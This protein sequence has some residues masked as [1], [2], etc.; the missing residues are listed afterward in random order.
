[1]ERAEKDWIKY[2]V[3]LMNQLKSWLGDI[4]NR[5]TTNIKVRGVR[6]FSTHSEYRIS[7]SAE[8]NDRIP[9]YL[10]IPRKPVKKP[11]P[12]IFAAHQCGHHCDIGKEQ[13]VGKFIDHPDQ[14]YG[15]EL[16]KRGF[17]VLAPDANKVG[18]RFDPKLRK[19]WQ[20]A[21]H[22]GGQ[23]ACC[24]A[25]GGS[26]GPINWKKVYDVMRGVDVLS[27][28]VGLDPKSIG[29]MGFSL[30][31]DTTLWAMPFDRRIKIGA[32]CPGGII[33]DFGTKGW[34]PYGLPYE[35][36][37]KLIAPRPFLEVTGIHDSIN[38]IEEETSKSIDEKMLKK[39]KAH[40][41]ATQIYHY[42]KKGNALSLIEFDGG[43]EFPKE[44]RIKCYEWFE[45]WMHEDTTY[46]IL[47]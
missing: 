26:W 38:Y 12:A 23:Q 24:S 13:V 3:E 1:M 29:M 28:W 16:V 34:D 4:P 44:M 37:L 20:T 43:H 18:E 6:E 19:Q 5:G 25:P 42:Y 35:D 47:F 15:L 2:R 27:E 30:G 22:I 46:P 31:S 33:K 11:I 17:A 32:V 45:K 9:A 8:S 10:L 40:Q 36:I 14:A 41:N 7:Y 21:E 39:R